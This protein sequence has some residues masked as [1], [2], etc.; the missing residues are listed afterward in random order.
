[1]GSEMC[2]RDSSGTP[3]EFSWLTHVDG[4]LAAGSIRA[5]NAFALP[6]S[7]PWSYLRDARS[8]PANGPWWEAFSAGRQIFRMDCLSDGPAEVVQC[9]FPR[10]DSAGASLL[11]MRLVNRRGTNAW[12]LAVYRLVAT[13]DEPAGL[14]V[15]PAG[16]DQVEIT[17]QLA[18]RAYRHRFPRR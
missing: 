16:P 18:G 1:M 8:A 12:F 4:S 3:R 7:A 11:P 6:S 10:D 17:L 15:A 13:P 5:T 14:G 2:I 9:G